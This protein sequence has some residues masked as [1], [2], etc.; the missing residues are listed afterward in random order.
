[1]KKQRGQRV[2]AFIAGLVT[3]VMVSCADGSVA[4]PD[5]DEV[6]VR[7][8]VGS[9]AFSA[10]GDIVLDG[11]RPAG[12]SWAAAAQ[13]DSLGGIVLLAFQ[14]SGA[15]AEEGDLFVLQLFPAVEGGFES[16]KLFADCHGRLIRNFG[17]ESVRWFEAVAGR[18][19]VTELTVTRMRGTF[20]LTLRD[21]GG[22]GSETLEIEGG[23]FDVPVSD[24]PGGFICGLPGADC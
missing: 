9:E 2:L 11:G 14:G 13:P 12:D 7:F 6:G 1:M 3:M 21:E 15:P 16:C 22:E 18:V 20:E 8:G 23:T 17:G 4:G 5:G 24:L 10:S 19:D